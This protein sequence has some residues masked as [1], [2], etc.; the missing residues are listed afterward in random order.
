MEDGLG[1]SSSSVSSLS[2]APSSALGPEKVLVSVHVSYTDS[3]TESNDVLLL[4]RRVAIVSLN[5]HLASAAW[6]GLRVQMDR[7]K[8]NLRTVRRAPGT[9]E[10]WLCGAAAGGA[11]VLQT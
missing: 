8:S 2:K 9:N 3:K 1:E 11:Q 5:S 6:L 4:L 7:G 10:R